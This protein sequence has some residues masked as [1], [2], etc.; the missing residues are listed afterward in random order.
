MGSLVLAGD[1][2]TTESPGKSSGMFLIRKKKKTWMINGKIKPKHLVSLDCPECHAYYVPEF[3][4]R[5]WGAIRSGCSHV[6]LAEVGWDVSEQRHL[7]SLMDWLPS[8]RGE[9]LPISLQQLWFCF[10]QSQDVSWN[11][12][13][14]PIIW[15]IL[16]RC[17]EYLLS[18]HRQPSSPPPLCAD[19]AGSL[20]GTLQCSILTWNALPPLLTLSCITLPSC[21]L[22]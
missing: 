8:A 14:A 2:F 4:H 15:G 12:M 1:F 6:W 19:T 13:I 10:P 16:E 22:P 21:S 17:T 11:G 20:W 5:S 18:T 9:V 3:Y 7:A